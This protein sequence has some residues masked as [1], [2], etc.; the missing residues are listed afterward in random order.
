MRQVDPDQLEHLAKLLDGEDGT[1]GAL[2]EA[3]TRA[4]TLGVT[5]LLSGLRPIQ[6]WVTDTAPDLRTRAG[7]AR[8]DEGDP[9]AGLLIAGF[10]PDELADFDGE[11]PAD[12]LLLANSMAADE[13]TDSSVFERQ[14]R[15]RSTTT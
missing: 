6:T 9:T 12:A 1:D 2:S 3:F 5:S 7:Y 11:V 4:S 14:H 15:E 10:T 8:L 13:N